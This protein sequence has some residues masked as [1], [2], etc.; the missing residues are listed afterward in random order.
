MSQSSP[1]LWIEVDDCDTAD[2]IVRQSAK[3]HNP[4]AKAIMYPPQELFPSIKSIENNCKAAKTKD[5][6]LRYQVRLGTNNLELWLKSLGY[7]EYYPADL[8]VFGP[9]TKP[10]L[11]K[12]TT[13]PN[14][15]IIPSRGR[16]L[17]RARESPEAATK[18]HQALNH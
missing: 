4:N 16:T 1:I 9:Y 12:I 10:N 2:M 15:G 11:D 8:T 7:K 14:F 6:N 5:S 17:K 3:I 18:S 13:L